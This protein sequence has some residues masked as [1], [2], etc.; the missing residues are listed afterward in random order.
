MQAILY[1]DF[2]CP[3]CYALGE[4]IHAAG[5]TDRIEWRGVQHAPHLAIPMAA[6]DARLRAE[7]Q[8]EVRA[9]QRLAPEIALAVP[10][11]KP[12]TAAAIVAVASALGRDA[13]RAHHF[14]DALYRAFWQQG[15]DLSD[16]KVLSKL[17]Q[18]SGLS[19]A[20]SAAAVAHTVSRWQGEWMNGF[21]GVPAIL[22]EDGQRLEGLVPEHVL[23]D[24]LKS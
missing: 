2:N 17:A 7:L 13:L 24:F 19:D 8:A 6:A 4:R 1:S 21:R 14:K 23:R 3:F 9:I 18:E 12:N 11:G 16:R 22:R 20:G 10:V 5:L 15:A